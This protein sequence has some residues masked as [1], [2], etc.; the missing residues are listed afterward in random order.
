VN[1]LSAVNVAVSPA[2]KFAE[3]LR[4]NGMQMTQA[5]KLVVEEVFSDHEHFDADQLVER[6]SHRKDGKRVSRPTVYRAL[7]DMVDAGLLRKV[8]SRDGGSAV[9]EHD[10]GYPQHDHL[11]CTKTGQMIEFHN[12]E[13]REIIERV[14]AER[15]FHVTGHRLEVYGLSAEAHRPP[16][17]RHSMLDRI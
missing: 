17:R 7:K 1:D 16:K 8:A 6:M 13:I 15:G 9:F 2:E 10:Y 11:I 14:A 4:A 12:A 5:R 3:Y